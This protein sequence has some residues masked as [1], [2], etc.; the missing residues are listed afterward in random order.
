VD[1]FLNESSTKALTS[2]RL[3]SFLKGLSEKDV[4]LALF[5]LINSTHFELLSNEQQLDFIQ[6][7][8]SAFQLEPFIKTELWAIRTVSQADLAQ[9]LFDTI[10]EMKSEDLT[11]L[12]P[13]IRWML[14]AA[15]K[16][17]D[18]VLDSISLLAKDEYILLRFLISYEKFVATKRAQL[19]SIHILFLAKLVEHS[20]NPEIGLRSLKLINELKFELRN[21]RKIVHPF[22]VAIETMAQKSRLVSL[23]TL[24]TLESLARNDFVGPATYASNHS[25]ILKTTGRHLRAGYFPKLLTAWI[26]VLTSFKSQLNQKELDGFFK[27]I[28]QTIKVLPSDLTKTERVNIKLGLQTLLKGETSHAASKL[29]AIE[30]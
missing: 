30:F 19:D 1:H 2:N 29:M 24:Y 3:L 25:Q 15:K 20:K 17:T 16:Q 18:A 23:E 9:V 10:Q 14:K 7:C 13:L 11:V 26:G 8:E 22:F 4:N 27:I 21:Q 5:N 6:K 28:S 12:H